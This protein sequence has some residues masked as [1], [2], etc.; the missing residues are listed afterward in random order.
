MPGAS[1]TPADQ[2]VHESVLAFGDDLDGAV[3]LV[4]DPSSDTEPVGLILA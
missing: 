1:S 3:G 4:S 2:L